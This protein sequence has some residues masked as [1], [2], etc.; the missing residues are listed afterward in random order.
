MTTT[1]IHDRAELEAIQR[2]GNYRLANDI[3]LTDAPWTPLF[4]SAAPFIGL[5]DGDGHSL[6]GL[7]VNKAGVDYCGLFTFHGYGGT[8]LNL[9]LNEA[10]VIGGSYSAVL[11]GYN[12]GTILNCSVNG[13]VTAGGSSGVLVGFNNGLI[14]GCFSEGSISNTAHYCGGLAA[15]NDTAGVIRH[16]YSKAAV[17]SSGSHVGGLTGRN[18]G[19]KIIHSFSTGKVIGATSTGGLVGSVFTSHANYACT[20]NYWNTTTSERSSSACGSGRN[21]SQMKTQSTFAGWDFE[22]VWQMPED[23]YPRLSWENIEADLIERI[24]I[25]P[26]VSIYQKRSFVHGN[27][28]NPYSTKG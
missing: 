9:H 7:Q 28:V 8:I 2:D 24:G 6:C 10:S 13:V 27:H 25:L 20:G 22:T 17:T 12:R 21:T 4:T 26:D 23:S 11:A 16:C 15:Y 3:D 18:G 1:L 14:E 5:F 19:G